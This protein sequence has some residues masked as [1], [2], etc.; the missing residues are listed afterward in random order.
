MSFAIQKNTLAD[1]QQHAM[2]MFCL[3]RCRYLNEWIELMYFKSSIILLLVVQQVWHDRHVVL[4]I[5]TQRNSDWFASPM[6]IYI[7]MI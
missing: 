1:K 4:N 3:S 5:L 7:L 2:K 6:R